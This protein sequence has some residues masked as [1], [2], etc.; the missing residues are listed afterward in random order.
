MSLTDRREKVR[1]RTFRMSKT[2]SGVCDNISIGERSACGRAHMKYI[3]P[4]WSSKSAYQ[5]D[6]RILL[7]YTHHL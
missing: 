6:E 5:V 7:I 3:T 1:W 4:A 2:L